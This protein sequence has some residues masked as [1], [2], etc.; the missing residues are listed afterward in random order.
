MESCVFCHITE[1]SAPASIVYSDEKVI[2]FLDIQPVNPGHVLIIPKVHAGQLT[3]LDEETGARMFKVSM[4]IAEALRRSGVKCEGVN[5]FLADGE[6]A[7]QEVFHVHLHVFPRFVGD[8]FRMV[9]GPNYHLRPDRKES[10]EIASEIREAL[11]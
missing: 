1:G 10:D 4:R 3:E 6:V 9:H 8:G 2:A 5:L 11:G 7:G